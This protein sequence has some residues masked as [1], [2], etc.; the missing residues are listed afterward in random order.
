MLCNG[1]VFGEDVKPP[2]LDPRLTGWTDDPFCKLHE[3]FNVTDFCSA[4]APIHLQGIHV[5]ESKMSWT[6]GSVSNANTE[7]LE[8]FCVD[9]TGS[10]INLVTSTSIYQ[11][12]LIAF[13]GLS[14]WLI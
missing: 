7:F 1:R 10:K 8:L 12:S 3:E 5:Q 4:T 9:Q 14:L 2:W 6:S 11:Q 13:V